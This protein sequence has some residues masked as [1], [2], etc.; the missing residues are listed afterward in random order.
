MKKLTITDVE[1]VSANGRGQ[2]IIG[3]LSCG[4]GVA[5]LLSTPFTLGASSVIGGALTVASCASLV[6]NW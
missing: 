3:G 2:T 4:F 1:N 6:G 5:M